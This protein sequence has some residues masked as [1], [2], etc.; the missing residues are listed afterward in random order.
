MPIAWWWC[1][2]LFLDPSDGVFGRFDL[3]A[4]CGCRTLYFCLFVLFEVQG[5][6][7]L[8]KCND[9][10]SSLQ[11]AMM[12]GNVAVSDAQ[13]EEAARAQ[14]AAGDMKGPKPPTASKAMGVDE[15][16][17]KGVGGALLPRK[18]QDRKDKEKKKRALGQSSI[19]SWKT[20][21]EMALRQ[22]FDS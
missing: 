11:I 18:Q 22:Q 15:F 12:G 20:E 2:P 9:T 19:G 4:F 8:T 16:L 21:A 3:A 7:H 17:E 13:E 5:L 14:G 1:S 10:S 6:W